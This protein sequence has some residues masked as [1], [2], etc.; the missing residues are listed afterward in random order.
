MTTDLDVIVVGAGLSGV[1]AAYRLTHECPNKSFTIL[2]ARDAIG[3]TWDLF[4]YPGIRSDSDMFTLG[5]PFHPWKQ[6]KSIAEGS[7]ILE[8]I[9]ETAKTF[10][11]ERHIRFRHRVVSATWST[12]DARWTL[13]VE[14]GEEKKVERYSCRFLYLCSGYY[15]YDSAHSPP[16]PGKDR[17]QGTLIHPQWWPED[18]DYGGKRVVVIGSGATA[19]TLV[20]A[21]AERAAHVTMLQRSPSY[22]ASLPA[23]DRF[24][25]AMRRLLSERAAHRVVRTKNVVLA[26]GFYQFCRRFPKQ[27]ARLLKYGVAQNLPKGYPVEKHFAPKYKPWDQRLCLVPDADLFLAL[28]SGKASIVT[29]TIET[30]TEQGIRLSSGEEL[31]ADIIVTATGLELVPCGGIHF[32]VDDKTINPAQTLVYKGLMLRDVPNLAWCVGYTNASWTLRADLSSQWVCRLLNT[33]DRR[34][35]DI[36]TPRASGESETDTELRPLLDLTSGYVARANSALPKQ[37]SKA[38]WY[39]RQN[40][41][42]DFLTM[43][44][45]RVDDRTMTFSRRE[46]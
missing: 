36:A 29:D 44:L 33:M 10:D 17:Y 23:V 3:G 18:L 25:T 40:Y 4:R 35:Y 12:K 9:R 21:L 45:G 30:F 5:Y 14:V 43:Q 20:P 32:E 41:I 28:S 39:L 34:G 24:A 1:G 2:E 22:I 42:L 6:S 46:A 16:F 13:T 38:P 27:A 8:Y 7:A 26:V 19:V 31:E 11:V 37:G 15:K